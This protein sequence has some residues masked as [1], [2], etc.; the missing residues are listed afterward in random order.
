MMF[1]GK[2]FRMV[3]SLTPLTIGWTVP[4]T[5]HAHT[6]II[7]KKMDVATYHNSSNCAVTLTL[8]LPLT[9]GVTI[10]LNLYVLYIYI[11][12]YIVFKIGEVSLF[13][14]IICGILTWYYG[15]QTNPEEW[16]R[17]TK[18]PGLGKIRENS[19]VWQNNLSKGE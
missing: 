5:F 4:L 18:F 17:K 3:Y 7:N 8:I 6:F 11:S 14:Y 10:L 15:F 19:L 16:N 2:S 1:F 13:L 12:S 9:S